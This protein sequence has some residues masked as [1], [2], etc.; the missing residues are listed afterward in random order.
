VKACRNLRHFDRHL[1]R[2]SMYLIARDVR[3][4]AAA[5]ATRILAPLPAVDFTDILTPAL[6]TQVCLA[7]KCMSS[8]EQV[9]RGC[10][11]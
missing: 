6:A 7:S 9:V 3:I 8:Y 5:D 2:R 4:E 1:H 10:Y 11:G